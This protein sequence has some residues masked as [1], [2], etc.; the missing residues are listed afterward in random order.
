MRIRT[1]VA[2]VLLALVGLVVMAPAAFAQDSGSSSEPKLS[3]DTR[4]CIEQA[5]KADDP[6]ACQQAPSPI[7]PATNE[8]VWGS[9]SFVVLFFLLRRFAYPA[10]KQGME[11]RSERIR[12]DLQTADSARSEAE[13]LLAEYRAQ[14]NDARSEAGHIIE[15]ARQTADALR[16]DQESRLQTELA[17]LRERA[18]ADLDAA[19]RQ[20]VADLRQEVAQ[21][22][23]GAAETVVG[24]NLD[25]ATQNQLI[26]DY[27]DE[28]AARRS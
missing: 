19:K 21:I 16:R 8:L 12:S 26:D 4:E 13:G 9:L 11:A 17:D 5:E 15:E 23:I 25:A 6:E 7:K 10:I 27:I 20:A 28:I 1:L 14:L 3:K 18:V 22:A 24:R 2:G